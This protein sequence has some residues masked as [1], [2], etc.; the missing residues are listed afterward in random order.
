MIQNT[1]KNNTKQNRK[2]KKEEE[3]QETQ[4]LRQGHTYIK[5]IKAKIK[6]II[7]KVKTL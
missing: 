2:T 6:S 1:I 3:S 4:S 7:Y 5:P